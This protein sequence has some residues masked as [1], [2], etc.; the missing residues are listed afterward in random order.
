[1]HVGN[2]DTRES[3]WLF[4]A[5]A[6]AQYMEPGVLLLVRQR[7][8]FA[9]SFDP[10]AL[11]FR[12]DATP[13]AIAPDI[14]VDD[15]N[16][17]AVSVARRDMVAYRRGAA[18][19]QRHLIWFDREGNP[20]ERVG[21]SDGAS[22]LS[23]SLSPD[24]RR[25][26]LYRTVNGNM[27][28]WTLEMSSGVLS[29]LTRDDTNELNPIWSPDGGRIVFSKGV[30][31]GL[32]LYERSTSTGEETLFLSTPQLKAANDWSPDGRFVL[33][34][35]SDERTGRDLWAVP[36]DGEREPIPVATAEYDEREGQFS[37]DGRFVAYQSNESGMPQI[38]IQRFPGG[39][40]RT[41]VTSAGGAQVRW[42]PEGNE[43]FYVALDD[44]LMSLPI[45]ADETGVEAGVPVPLFPTRIGGAVRGPARQQYL[46]SLD[47]ERFLMNTVTEEASIPIH[48]RMRRSPVP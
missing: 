40:D 9:Q 47:G 11:E 13:V 41:Q 25:L 31:G 4:D 17:A 34:R 45:R 21:D 15:Q 42:H 29:P 8:L 48:I 32:D 22:A 1:M 12:G 19:E 46:L 7:T 24:G 36:V 28:L 10:A 5:D 27:D 20:V 39:E 6:V 23:P 26:V 30:G 14:T 35:S 2:I 18:L 3:R 38:W 43:L 37:P 16:V 44:M 33:Y